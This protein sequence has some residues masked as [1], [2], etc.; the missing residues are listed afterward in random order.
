[1]TARRKKWVLLGARLS[2]PLLILSALISFMM[3]NGFHAHEHCMKQ[4]GLA[5]KTYALDHYGR[6][7]SDTNSFGNALL[8]LVK[9]EK[10]NVAFITGPGDNGE[11]FKR[12]LRTGE[13][14][15]ERKCSR[16]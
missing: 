13:P 12:A 5:F 10:E 6:F 3:L 1:M 11:I 14:I 16:I 4:A 7:P 15:P 9:E 8:L 2:T